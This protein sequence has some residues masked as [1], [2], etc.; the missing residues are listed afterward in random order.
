M[1]SKQVAKEIPIE[2]Q[3]QVCKQLGLNGMCQAFAFD[4]LGRRAD[5][6]DVRSDTYLNQGVVA[7]IAMNQAEL[8]LNRGTEVIEH[9]GI[10]VAGVSSL[11]A[12]HERRASSSDS[13]P[14]LS[15]NSS[16]DASPERS[17]SPVTGRDS[18]ISLRAPS[19]TPHSGLPPARALAS[20]SAS[21]AASTSLPRP[22]TQAVT[23]ELSSP[24]GLSDK[25]LAK[26]A[27]STEKSKLW[28][29]SCD[30]ENGRHGFALDLK[31]EGQPRIAD[32]G[33]GVVEFSELGTHQAIVEHLSLLQPALGTCRSW[34]MSAIRK[35]NPDVNAGVSEP[36]SSSSS[37]G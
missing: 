9:F 25:L 7:C 6:Q 36:G 37:E 15:G 8:A 24:P 16:R 26:L 28:Y 31:N 21:T 27:K 19:N 23:E 33:S 4:Y 18:P 5:N 22:A 11:K 12:T 29:V 20:S 35:D 3:L 32:C 10:Q 2:T 13:W 14:S 30:F 1:P 17:E 34:E